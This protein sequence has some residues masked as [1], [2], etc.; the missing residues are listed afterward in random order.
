MARREVERTKVE[1]DDVVAQL[2][3][4]L[5][6]DR[7]DDA[8]GLVASL[9]GKLV[10]DNEKLALDVMRLLKRHN[11]ETSE[12]ISAAQLSLLAAIAQAESTPARVPE[13]DLP[14]P[15]VE[16]KPQRRREKK[17]G[18]GRKPL[19]AH[20]PRV[21][22]PVSAVPAKERC[23]TTCGDERA[24]IDYETSETLDFKPASLFVT[25]HRREKLACRRCEEHVVTAPVDDKP[26]DKGIPGPGLLAHVIVSK[27]ANHIPLNRLHMI[28]KREGVDIPTSTLV[29]WVRAAHD[30]LEPLAKRIAALA[31]I[32]HVLQVDDTGLKVLDKDAPGGTK[33]GHLWGMVGDGKWAAYVFTP[34]WQGKYPQAFLATRT[35]PL[36][37]DAYAG[38]DELFKI[39]R[40][41]E[42]GCWAHARRG[43]V[44]CLEAGDSRAAIPIEHIQAL[45]RVEKL[46]AEDGVDDAE[47]LRR[48]QEQS[49]AI[50]AKLK[51]WLDDVREREPPSSALAKAAGYCLRQWRALNRFTEDARL[52]LDNNAAER[53]LR[54][55][56]LGRR[57]YLFAG[58]EEGGKRAATLY[59]LLT[60][61]ALNGVEPWEYLTDV[62]AKLAGGWK[63]SRLDELL[64]PNWKAAR[65]AA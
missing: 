16:E 41:F 59:T 63:W 44:E 50:L 32:A 27:Y 61:C 23:C 53:A 24:F 11:G 51:G 22:A 38:F 56:A 7:K 3:S 30:V 39:G 2:A 34:T 62:F 49:R 65:A 9:L 8:L 5:E 55:I 14:A 10:A 25:V 17:Q 15:V 60:T 46:A 4:L 58:S 19:P 52:P 37:A 1:V 28:L 54:G 18:H 47:R 35:G 36:V 33:K 45:Y 6:A 21:Y 64:P 20:L 29:G 43:F 40:A 57:N 42:V 12:R 48:R 26:I 31:L 13:G